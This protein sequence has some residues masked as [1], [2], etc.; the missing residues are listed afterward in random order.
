[1]VKR[2]PAMLAQSRPPLARKMRRRSNKN[3]N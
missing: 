2:R 1:V 3:E